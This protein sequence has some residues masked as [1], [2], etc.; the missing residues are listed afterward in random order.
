MTVYDIVTNITSVPTNDIEHTI[1]Y[2]AS[3]AIS[4]LLFFAV[5]Y[6]FKVISKLMD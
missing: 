5:V 2:F 1:A 3:A 6:I 4:V